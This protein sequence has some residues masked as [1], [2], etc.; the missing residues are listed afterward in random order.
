MYSM[1]LVIDVF[2][3]SGSSVTTI[4]GV[5]SGASKMRTRVIVAYLSAL[6]LRP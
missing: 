2:S 5:A 3:F 1:M 6:T 4:T